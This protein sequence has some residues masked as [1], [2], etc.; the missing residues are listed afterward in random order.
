MKRTD[1]ASAQ[2]AMRVK[3]ANSRGLRPT[4]FLARAMTFGLDTAR[5]RYCLR[6][7]TSIG[8]G[9]RVLGHAPVVRNEGSLTLGNDVKLEAPVQP[10]F[11]RVFPGAE[12]TLGDKVAVNDGARIECTTAISVGKRARIGFGA[13]LID[14]HFHEPYDRDARPAGKPIVIENDVWIG[15]R[16]IVLPG[17]RIGE[18]SIVGAGAIVS[19]AVPP[20]VVV[21]GNPARVIRALSAELFNASADATPKG[22][23]D[24][25]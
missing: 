19:K 21:A 4:E 5:S 14:N 17:V 1:P 24:A 13:V 16:A 3:L 18:G 15:S 22:A 12:L 20:Y 23:G 25:R 8:V 6:C 7:A 11:L 10:I 9:V 2:E